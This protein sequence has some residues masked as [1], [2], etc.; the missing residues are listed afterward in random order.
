MRALVLTVTSESWPSAMVWLRS[1]A[2]STDAIAGGRLPDQRE[3]GDFERQNVYTRSRIQC[4]YREMNIQRT[5]VQRQ[6][7][8]DGLGGEG[9]TLSVS[10]GGEVGEDYGR[11]K[12]RY[13][14]GIIM[15][16]LCHAMQ[17]TNKRS[18]TGQLRVLSISKCQL[19]R[20][21]VDPGR[22]AG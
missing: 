5:Q 15:L 17:T 2:K 22:P 11:P 6:N 19:N 14:A 1:R 8:R 13:C 12:K 20:M 3:F 21:L 10:V 18:N 7:E 9:L 16:S 4:T